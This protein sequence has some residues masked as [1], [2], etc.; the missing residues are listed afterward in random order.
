MNMDE[1]AQQ[2]AVQQAVEAGVKQFSQGLDESLPTHFLALEKL[3]LAALLNGWLA[4]ER[5]R[6]PFTVQDCERKEKLEIKGISVE[7][8]LDRVDVLPDG[9][10]VV[11]D[12]KTG[13]QVSPNSWAEDRISEPQLPIYAALVLIEGEVAA[14]C[15]AKVRAGEHQFVGIANDCRDTARR[16]G[17]GRSA[18]GVRRGEIPGMARPAATLARQPGGHRR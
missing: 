5:E 6:P 13:A 15:F 9:R 11:L 8:K 16:K 14:V 1:S 12:Y 4:L 3:R 7:L 17:T 2:Q 18:Q 10:M